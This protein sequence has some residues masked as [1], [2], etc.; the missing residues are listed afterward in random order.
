MADKTCSTQAMRP[1][2]F[3]QNFGS[4]EQCERVAVDQQLPRARRE[5]ETAVAQLTT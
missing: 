5:A 2:S 3:W 4:G 1:R